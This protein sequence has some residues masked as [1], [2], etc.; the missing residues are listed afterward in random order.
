MGLHPRLR[1]GDREVGGL[2]IFA[3]VTLAGKVV[4]AALVCLTLSARL[5][6]TIVFVAPPNLPTL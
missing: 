5:P 2:Y 6:G 1:V 4:D 3:Q